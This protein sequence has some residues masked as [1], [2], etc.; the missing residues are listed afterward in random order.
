MLY[1]TNKKGKLEQGAID[2]WILSGQ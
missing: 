1:A 2:H